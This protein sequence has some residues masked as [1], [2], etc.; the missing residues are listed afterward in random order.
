MARFETLFIIARD[1]NAEFMTSAQNDSFLARQ[2]PFNVFL[3][4]EDFP[5]GIH[6]L[7]TFDAVFLEDGGGPGY[8]TQMVWKFDLLK[9]KRLRDAAIRDAAQSHMVIISA[10]GTDDLP[11]VVRQWMEGWVNARPAGP[12]ALV[13]MLDGGTS[14]PT[15]RFAIESQ[16]EDFGRRAGMDYFIQRVP[17]R[18]R[19]EREDLGATTDQD[20]RAF[21]T[22]TQTSPN[23]PGSPGWGLN[24]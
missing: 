19:L 7:R 16:L 3:A 14:D 17:G 2:A 10:H 18:H 21:E 22:L 4:Y 15:D 9:I 6:A 8:D 13:V 23:S 24:D 5:T 20:W 12:G 11:L 1:M